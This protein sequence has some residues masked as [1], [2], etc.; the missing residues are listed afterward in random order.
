MRIFLVVFLTTLLSHAWA[1]N[2]KD[3]P[4]QVKDAVNKMVRSSATT[5]DIKPSVLPDLYE[6][7]IGG[8]I[9]YIAADGEHVIV[10][11]I[12]HLDSG[13][14]LTENRRN[15]IR[16]DALA[17]I[18]ENK[19]VVFSP[20]KET[21]HTVNVFTDVDCPY[22]SKLHDEVPQ[23]NEAGIKVRY[24]A[25]PRAGFGS[26]TYNTMVSVWCAEDQQDAMTKAKQRQPVKTATCANPVNEQYRI[27]Q[28]VGIS[29][30][31]AIVLESGEIIGG[32]VPADKLIAT[33]SQRN[34][35]TKP[36][37]AR[38]QVAQ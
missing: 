13:T 9:V 35:E 30:T 14:N 32:Y 22:C 8:Y 17:K 16:A 28:R 34:S 37:V 36:T 31:P 6:A 24:L 10:G 4:V 23:L 38:P 25:F 15:G 5:V 2:G 3:I 12:R 33:L 29:G 18:P 19:M 21:K 20:E 26:G 7:V 11:E 1:A 27:G